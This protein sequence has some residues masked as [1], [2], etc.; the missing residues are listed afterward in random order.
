MNF[1][2]AIGLLVVLGALAA[3]GFFMLRGGAAT[4]GDSD[5][6]AEAKRKRMARA[7]TVRIGVSVAVFLAILLAWH[8]GY[9]K[10][11]G[12]PVGK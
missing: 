4:E 5:A 11:T 12:L 2:T 3:A 9:L 10:P 8:L 1:V 7:L 6:T